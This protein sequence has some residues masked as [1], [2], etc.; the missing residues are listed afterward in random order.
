MAIHLRTTRETGRHLG[1]HYLLLFEYRK[2]KTNFSVAHYLKG[3]IRSISWLIFKSS[4]AVP[5]TM[6]VYGV[7]SNV[8]FMGIY[9]K[10]STSHKNCKK[11]PKTVL[12]GK[13]KIIP[14]PLKIKYGIPI[15]TNC[16]PLLADL[17]LY[18]YETE[19]LQKQ[20]VLHLFRPKFQIWQQ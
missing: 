10:L 9:G 3:F 1:F 8:V 12:V 4:E 16:A 11:I 20:H 14:V 6:H 2:L 15:G 17:F 19:F 5:C 18:S 7:V 13:T